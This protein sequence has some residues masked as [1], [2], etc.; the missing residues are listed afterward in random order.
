MLDRIVQIPPS[1]DL[2]SAATLA[3]IRSEH[4]SV[5]NRI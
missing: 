1:K 4:P 5:T 2:D 3:A